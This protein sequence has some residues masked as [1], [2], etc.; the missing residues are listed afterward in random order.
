MERRFTAAA[1][2]RGPGRS[3]MPAPKTRTPEG[4]VSPLDESVS[5][6]EPSALYRFADRGRHLSAHLRDAARRLNLAL[7]DYR[8]RC[9]GIPPVAT[10]DLAEKL[11]R[12]LDEIDAW[13]AWVRQVGRAF[14]AAGDGELL[15]PSLP[16]GAVT[17]I[18]GSLASGVPT[19]GGEALTTRGPVGAGTSSEPSSAMRPGSAA[20]TGTPGGGNGRQVTVADA[21]PT[22][23]P[24]DEEPDLPAD[25]PFFDALDGIW[26]QSD[27]A[28]EFY[29]RADDG[30]VHALRGQNWVCLPGGPSPAAGPSDATTSGGLVSSRHFT[31]TRQGNDLVGEMDVCWHDGQEGHN[32]E[33]APLHLTL[34]DDGDQLTGTWQ[35][36]VSGAAVELTLTRAEVTPLAPEDLGLPPTN[37]AIR[38]YGV[39]KAHRLDGTI[40][41]VPE[42]Y[43]YDPDADEQLV[44]HRGVDFTSRD[45]GWIVTPLPFGAPAGGT[46]HVYPD[47]PWNTIGLRLDTG[48]W[49]QFLH[50]SEVLVQPGQRVEAG[51]T[52]GKTGATGASA[53]HLHLQARSPAGAFLD[54]RRVVARARRAARADPV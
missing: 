7:I 33:P 41:T 49:L 28:G 43:M 25:A 1:C 2:R 13:D 32:W 6:A 40:A 54:P 9:T 16:F 39:L 52:L 37:L 35:N 8:S 21:T 47:S 53:I 20:L 15:P 31:A 42:E 50:A 36:R 29:L 12:Y 34:S 51:A 5:S 45:V 38:G 46:V 27:V 11:Q 17:P 23:P 4:R 3:I 10:P 44:R 26:T 24:L 22:E 19:A 18:L 30:A 48:D 14:E